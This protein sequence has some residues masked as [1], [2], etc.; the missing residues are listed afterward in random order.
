M[1]SIGATSSTPNP[2]LRQK[3]IELDMKYEFRRFHLP[4]PFFE[5]RQEN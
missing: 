2:K 3:H 4:L 5:S 1:A